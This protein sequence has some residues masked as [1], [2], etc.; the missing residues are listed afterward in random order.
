MCIRFFVCVFERLSVSVCLSVCLSGFTCLYECVRFVDL[1]DGVSHRYLKCGCFS[2]FV[3]LIIYLFVCL[4][5][6]VV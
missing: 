3:C 2:L 1:C 5:L 4:C 6:S